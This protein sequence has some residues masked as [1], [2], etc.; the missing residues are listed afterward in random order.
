MNLKRWLIRRCCQIS[1]THGS[2]L[3]NHFS[4]RRSFQKSW[5]TTRCQIQYNIKWF[6]L[7]FL[8]FR[9]DILFGVVDCLMD[10]NGVFQESLWIFGNAHDVRHTLF[11]QELTDVTSQATTST[12]DQHSLFGGRYSIGKQ[13]GR[14]RR[15]QG[16]GILVAQRRRYPVANGDMDQSVLSQGTAR[17]LHETCRNTIA[18]PKQRQILVVPGGGVPWDLH[19]DSTEITTGHVRKGGRSLQ[20]S[21]ESGKDPHV[22]GC[23]GNGQ[24]L[25]QKKVFPLTGW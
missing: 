8:Y 14:A 22:T 6:L 23:Q 20:F 15:C 1:T 4:R 11:L 19:D 18:H 2:R 17:T 9:V 24:R 10:G 16:R 21:R 13:D 12:G 7:K 3:D 25:D 5:P